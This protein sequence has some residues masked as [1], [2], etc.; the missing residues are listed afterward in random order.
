MDYLASSCHMILE[1]SELDRHAA[2]QELSE[3]VA[4][5]LED[6]GAT[7][8]SISTV[9][10]AV[11]ALKF[12]SKT[13][14]SVA[15]K[16]VGEDKSH[17]AATGELICHIAD[18]ILLYGGSSKP[19][20][21]HTDF[22]LRRGHR[23][24]I[25]GR[26][27]AGKTTLMSALVNKAVVEL[28][29]DL[30]VVHVHGGSV[31][32]HDDPGIT[33]LH[34]AELHCTELHLAAKSDVDVRTAL[35]TVGFTADMQDKAIGE[36]SGGWRMRLA[37]A[38]AMLEKCDVLLLDEPT[39]H[40]DAAAISW[41]SAYLQE[42]RGTSLI[43]SHERQFLNDVCTDIIHFD[44]HKLKYYHG[45][46]H[47]FMSK[48]AISSEEAQA[49]LE[50]RSKPSSK[51]IQI[52]ED[53]VRIS[54]PIPG[55]ISGINC[56]SRPILEMKHIS[57]QYDSDTPFILKQV[58]AKVSL[59]SR[60]AILGANGSGKSTLLSLLCGEVS[61]CAFNGVLGN[62]VR[63]PNMRLSY[64]AQH[65]SFHLEEFLKCTPVQYFQIRFR[66][67]YDE[68]LQRRL[69]DAGT[70]EE[71]MLRR[72]LAAKHGKYGHMVRDVVG[73]HKKGKDF[74][75]E[76]AWEGLDDAKQNTF[77]T[78]EKLKLMRVDG[79]ARAYD[80]RLASIAAG[81]YERPLTEREIIHHLESFQISEEMCTKQMIGGFS[82]GQ[83]SRMM[84]G[85][86]CWTKPHVIVCDEPTNHLDPET[87]DALA[88]ALKHFKGG[89]VVATHC[90]HFVE[91]V[92]SEAWTIEDARVKVSKL[93]SSAS[94]VVAPK[95]CKSESPC[96]VPK[97]P[98][99]MLSAAALA[100]ERAAQRARDHQEKAGTN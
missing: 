56:A 51:A 26:N 70:D 83:K 91:Q 49:L 59:N 15:P 86:A 79:V 55:K 77:E 97:A 85:A 5:Y 14:I 95:V 64:I 81:V 92:C 50:T 61:P 89:V 65:H 45:N 17:V 54:F 62:V 6:G 52:R 7:S 12:N 32:D 100:V 4:P 68:Q 93:V 1:D 20:L 13:A 75:Y 87:V 90:Q 46:F 33:A 47:N 27:G 23:Y 57:F 73:R 25:V 72:D 88:V 10:A 71:R 94:A 69:L 24:G 48:A 22:E 34:F 58:C 19:L 76:I 11:A 31:L 96:A 98:A 37:L 9:C 43:I 3:V 40:L 44:N 82:G 8:D 16:A 60:V 66:N 38:C 28:P 74:V 39:N 35:E 18:L 29:P 63:H 30:N 2:E 80:E 99:V 21:D 42:L 67:G 78:M 41:L 53:D 84:L 36:L